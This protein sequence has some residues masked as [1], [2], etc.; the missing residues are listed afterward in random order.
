VSLDPGGLWATG[1]SRGE[2]SA[3]GKEGGE[4]A[5]ASKGFGKDRLDQKGAVGEERSGLARDSPHG[6][7]GNLAWGDR[8]RTG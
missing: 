6:K 3:G 4:K 8:G 2:T 1:V 7:R 5:S